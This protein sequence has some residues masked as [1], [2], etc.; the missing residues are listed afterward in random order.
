VFWVLLLGLGWLLLGEGFEL[1]VTRSID[2][3]V[4]DTLFSRLDGS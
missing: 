3:E 2:E 1:D 4:D